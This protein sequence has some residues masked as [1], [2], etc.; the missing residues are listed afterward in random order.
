MSWTAKHWDRRD[1]HRG[2]RL[3]ALLVMTALSA[4]MGLASPGWT[5]SAG[6]GSGAPQPLLPGNTGT[7]TLNPALGETDALP[8]GGPDGHLPSP[9]PPPPPGGAATHGAAPVPS[10]PYAAQ[11]GLAVSTPP[12]MVQGSRDPAD[13][14]T[15]AKARAAVAEATATVRELRSD[16]GFKKDVSEFLARARAVAVV[17]SFFR[18]GFFVGGAYGSTLLLVRDA[19]GAFSHP[20]FFTMSAGSLGFQ[21]GIQDARILLLIMTDAGL[22]AIMQDQFKLEANANVT[23]GIVGGG[24]STGSTTDINQDIIAV[25]HSRGLF[26]GG[27]LEGA[28]IEPRNDW[29]AIFYESPGIQPEQIVLQRRIG[30]PAAIPLIEALQAPYPLPQ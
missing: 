5:Q 11:P 23:F 9:A 28:L 6:A 24:I 27:A 21:F 10:Q 3:T 17:P 19:N 16:S 2:G 25:S 29:N 1:G 30:N 14:E 20:A 26:G 22:N 13:A 4:T 15:L 7:G 12:T 18:A 8:P